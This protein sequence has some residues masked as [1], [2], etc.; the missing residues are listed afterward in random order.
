[1][2]VTSVSIASGVSS[3]R[4]AC[5]LVA[6]GLRDGSSL[7]FAV[8]VYFGVMNDTATTPRM[9]TAA[10]TATR[11]FHRRRIVSRTTLMTSA[12]RASYSSAS[13]LTSMLV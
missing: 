7:T 13:C 3:A 4:C 5:A 6:S 2:A 9:N 8:E 1:M 12:S 10:V 11:I